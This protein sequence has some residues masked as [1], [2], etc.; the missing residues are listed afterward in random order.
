[1]TVLG[2][3]G[4]VQLRDFEL[5]PGSSHCKENQWRTFGYCHF[6]WR[7][8]GHRSLKYMHFDHTCCTVNV[9]LFLRCFLLAKVSSKSPPYVSSESE[10]KA[11]NNCHF[12]NSPNCV[13][14]VNIKADLNRIYTL[15]LFRN[16]K[17]R[18]PIEYKQQWRIQK[19]KGGGY[20]SSKGPMPNTLSS[21][22]DA[23]SSAD[24]K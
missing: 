2:G 10:G 5:A 9:V 24:Q 17:T 6:R 14:T 13:P 1:M 20:S 22:Q 4:L 3:D 15:Y 18:Y 19:K 11:K 23:L 7:G 12:N 16:K 21:K 8:G